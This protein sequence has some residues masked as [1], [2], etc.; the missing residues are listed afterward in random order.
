[1]PNDSRTNIHLDLLRPQSNPEKIWVILIRWLFSTG[2]YIL[3]FV[4]AV[5]L[6][7]FVTR[8]K[9]DADLASNKEAAENQ[10]PYIQSQRPVEV[11]I[12]QTQLKLATIKA[13]R[14]NSPDYVSILRHIS[15]QTPQGVK[16]LKLDLEKEVGKITIRI[17]GQAQSN[18]DVTTFVSGLKQDKEFSNVNLTS[19][20]LDQG[21]IHFSIFAELPLQVEG[22][23]KL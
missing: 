16:I 22:E 12:R 3:I 19:A 13:F 17:T 6:I 9:L 15:S 4:E 1:M 20:G 14:E 7:A 8:F 23:K 5:V 11:L 10:I 18:T 2:R 21:A